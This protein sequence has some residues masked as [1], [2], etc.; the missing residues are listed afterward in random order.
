MKR[1]TETVYIAQVILPVRESEWHI[2]SKVCATLEE[3][4][5]WV[6]PFDDGYRHVIIEK[7]EL[8]NMR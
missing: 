8:P 3:A 6:K 5:A 7:R 4:Q 1:K 2:S